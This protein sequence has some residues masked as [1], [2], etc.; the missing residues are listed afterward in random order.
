[1]PDG[2]LTGLRVLDLTEGI[3]GP[4]CTKLLGDFGAE[5][6]KVEPP[7]VGDWTRH[8]GPFYRDV[9][10]REHSMLFAYLNT[11]KRSVTLNLDTSF[12][13]GA[14]RRLAASADILVEAYPPGYLDE[15]GLSPRALRG[16]PA[17]AGYQ[18]PVALR[19]KGTVLAL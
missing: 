17:A 12:G 7:H 15:R 9:P 6:I 18:L 8:R 10:D 13:Q 4:S 2:P 16:E 1:M 19:P 14:V 11:N 5:V 3:A